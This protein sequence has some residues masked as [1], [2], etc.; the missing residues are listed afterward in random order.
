V[1]AVQLLSNELGIVSASKVFPSGILQPLPW[2]NSCSLLHAFLSV[3]LGF[4]L[5]R[6][7]QK[8][9]FRGLAPSRRKCS[10]MTLPSPW[11]P[12]V[13]SALMFFNFMR[14]TTEMPKAQD[15]DV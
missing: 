5:G 6:H 13:I 15:G 11:L 7:Q 3:W 1:S 10:V 2:Q 12:P 9:L 8:I 14:D 4:G